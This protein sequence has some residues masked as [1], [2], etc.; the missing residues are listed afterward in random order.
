MKSILAFE[1]TLRTAERLEF[2]GGGGSFIKLLFEVADADEIKEIEGAIFPRHGDDPERILQKAL[3]DAGCRV[4]VVGAL[5][6]GDKYVGT[7][8]RR[9]YPLRCNVERWH[10]ISQSAQYSTSGSAVQPGQ[11]GINDVPF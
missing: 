3:D 4:F 2:R 9:Y 7:N 1:A 10:V 8:G 11:S 5:K 6:V